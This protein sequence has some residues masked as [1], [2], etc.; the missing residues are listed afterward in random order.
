MSF[1]LETCTYVIHVCVWLSICDVISAVNNTGMI[2]VSTGKAVKHSGVL[3][4]D[5]FP[6][7][8]AL[9]DLNKNLPFSFSAQTSPIKMLRVLFLRSDLSDRSD[10]AQSKAT[11]KPVQFCL[12][13]FSLR[14]SRFG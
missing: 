2:A 7:H 10:F 9:I 4:C 11:D 14:I 8:V 3:G 1:V 12:F 6:D 5:L 13:T